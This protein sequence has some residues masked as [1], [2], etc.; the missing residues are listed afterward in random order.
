MILRASS[1]VLSPASRRRVLLAQLSRHHGGP[2]PP[3]LPA[4]G[5]RA[6]SC[7][8]CPPCLLF[9]VSW[10]FAVTSGVRFLVLLLASPLHLL[11]C[12][13]AVNPHA[14]VNQSIKSS[15]RHTSTREATSQRSHMGSKPRDAKR[16][17]L[18][19]LRASRA[20]VSLRDSLFVCTLF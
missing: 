16:R 12:L 8:G 9:G 20:S 3:P 15:K 14:S 6:V 4:I 11:C 2:V 17:R 18:G 10:S 7:F 1:N 19:G 13:R 5:T